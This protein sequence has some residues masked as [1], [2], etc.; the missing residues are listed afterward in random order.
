MERQLSPSRGPS[1]QERLVNAA[2]WGRA[3]RDRRIAPRILGFPIRRTYTSK[4]IFL[5]WTKHSGYAKSFLI[6]SIWSRMRTVSPA[7]LIAAGRSFIVCSS[8]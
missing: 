1:V 7:T 6:R 2:V 8:H 4:W 3:A 5:V